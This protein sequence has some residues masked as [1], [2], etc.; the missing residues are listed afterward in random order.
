MSRRDREQRVPIEIDAGGIEALPLP[1]IK[2]ILRAAEGIIA[3]G[4][5]TLLCK[6][7][8]GSRDKSVL[9]HA[10]E[11]NPSYGFYREL[12]NE[13]IMARIDWTILHGYLRLE[14]FGRL[15]LVCYTPA[16]LALEIDIITDELRERL[17]QMAG[18]PIDLPFLESLKDAPRETLWQLLEKIE[19]TGDPLFI[20]VLRAWG[21]VAYKKVRARIN[22]VIAE[23]E[24][25][26]QAQK[27]I[28]R[29]GAL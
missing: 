17:R 12:G 6:I 29:S 7:L 23:L 16:G 26:C 19:A 9:Q 8:K 5:R 15:P 18:T 22:R 13:E 25:S 20:P 14:Y 2:S 27:G 4:G 24:R 28:S 1:E 10:L 3:R 21:Q 11:N